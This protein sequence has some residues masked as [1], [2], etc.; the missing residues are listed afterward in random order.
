MS[1]NRP[2]EVGLEAS[3]GVD[4][5]QL[6]FFSLRLGGELQRF[7]PQVRTFRIR[8]RADRDVLAGCHRQRAGDAACDAREQDVGPRGG[9]CRHADQQT[10]RRDDPVVGAQHCRAEPPYVFTPMSF[11]MSHERPGPHS[12]A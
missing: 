5:S 4:G 2:C 6:V 12:L 9:R 3:V 7:A 11:A 1:R 8:L 10:G